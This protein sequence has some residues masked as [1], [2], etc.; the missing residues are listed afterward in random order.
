MRRIVFELC[1]ESIQAC[2]AAR[3]GGADRIELCSGLSE[4]GLTP[5]YGLIRYAIAKSELPVH[6]MVRPRG[7]DFV[8][9]DDEFAVM[10]EDL[11]HIRGVEGGAAA[12]VV[13]GLLHRD[14]SVD[15]ARTSRLVELAGPLEVTFH[16]AFDQTIDMEQALEDVIATGCRRVLTSGGELNVE[17]GAHSLAR[18][19]KQAAGR[20]DIAVGGG[21]RIE[22]ASSVA[23]ATGA[24]HFHGSLR[25]F[26]AERTYSG[27]DGDTLAKVFVDSQDVRTMVENLRSA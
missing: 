9:S 15:V 6:V 17:S 18:L 14:E 8:Y 27:G 12:G 13:L 3:E 19:V 4:G 23:R 26:V 7:G 5:S 21:L 25:H 2:V 22:N 1:A 20:I 24:S 16:R 10:C 11:M